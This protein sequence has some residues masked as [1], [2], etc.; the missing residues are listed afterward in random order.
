[1]GRIAEYVNLLRGMN[2]TVPRALLNLAYPLVR[3]RRLNATSVAAR[4]VDA[5][6]ARDRRD[7]SAQRLHHTWLRTD[8]Y[9]PFESHLNNALWLDFRYSG[10]PELLHQQDALG[11]AFSLKCRPPMLDHR[12]VE[13]CFALD[14]EQKI[15]C[16]WSKVLLRR[17]MKNDLPQGVL[18]RRDKRGCRRPS[19]L[20]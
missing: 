20:S 17:A 16:G 9:R 12:L 6:F 15:G 11:M 3:R 14:F 2:P 8:I 19:S 7:V 10:L 5:G 4:P 18:L 1:M 13:F